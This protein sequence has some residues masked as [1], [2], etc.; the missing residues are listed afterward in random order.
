[1]ANRNR[2]ILNDTIS[3]QDRSVLRKCFEKGNRSAVS[4]FLIYT[5][6]DDTEKE[7]TKSFKINN[8][9]LKEKYLD[10][11]HWIE[12]IEENYLEK[13]VKEIKAKEKINVVN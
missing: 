2:F 6:I 13:F 1:M 11:K 3:F 8:V 10:L 4:Y 7:F 5:I 9:K 12:T